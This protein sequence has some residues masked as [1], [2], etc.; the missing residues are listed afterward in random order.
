M[1]ELGNNE[2][3]PIPDDLLDIE[4]PFGW[5]DF[6]SFPDMGA[7]SSDLM[8]ELAADILPK[9]ESAGRDGKFT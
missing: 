3:L 6:S 9:A 2:I 8:D 7:F 1:E 4:I 5:F